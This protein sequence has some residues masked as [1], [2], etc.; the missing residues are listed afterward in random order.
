M[1]N[2]WWGNEKLHRAAGDGDIDTV[3]QLLEEGADINQFDEMGETP[4]HRA[5]D[6]ENLEMVKY[7]LSNGA[8]VDARDESQI[9]D[10]PLAKVAANCSLEMAEILVKAGADPTTPGWMQLTALHRAKERKKP[11]GVKVYELLEKAA[12][13]GV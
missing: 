7:L 5:V 12:R 8:N 2:D 1:N 10:T 13:K 4:L 9:V 11:E 3:R 6:S